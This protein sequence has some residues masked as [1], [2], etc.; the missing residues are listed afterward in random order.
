VQY[1]NLA[2]PLQLVALVVWFVVW[3]HLK[4]CPADGANCPIRN[5]KKACWSDLYNL[6]G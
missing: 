2:E 1:I 5:P 3:S 4:V 6:S